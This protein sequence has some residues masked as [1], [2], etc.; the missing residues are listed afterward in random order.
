[1]GCNGGRVVREPP[2]RGMEGVGGVMG[3]RLRG[4]NGRGR[5]YDGRG[6]TWEGEGRF[7]NG[8]CGL[9][10]GRDW[11]FRLHMGLDSLRFLGPPL[12]KG[13]DK[14]ELDGGWKKMFQEIEAG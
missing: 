11:M 9:A 7:A 12:G 1:M 4:N 14:D 2:L 8:L 6:M 5:G 13:A 3:S 10:K